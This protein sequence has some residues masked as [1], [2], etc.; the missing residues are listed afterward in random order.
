MTKNP[1]KAEKD[2]D[3]QHLLDT[4]EGLVKSRGAGPGSGYEAA[5]LDLLEVVIPSEMVPDFETP[6]MLRKRIAS[7]IGASA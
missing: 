6:A 7:R 3:Y 2:V 1:W 5:L 4:A